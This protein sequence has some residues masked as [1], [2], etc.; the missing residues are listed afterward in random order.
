VT[1]RTAPDHGAGLSHTSAVPHDAGAHGPGRT[2]EARGASDPL[3]V[4]VSGRP[5]S[6]K[7]TVAAQLASA[8]GLS[9]LAKDA[10][11][12]TL[13]DVLGA[14]DVEASR[15]LGRAARLVLTTVAASSTGAVL[16]SVWP[17]GDGAEAALR[18]LPGR[19]VEVHCDIAPELAVQRYQARE[20]QRGASAQVDAE[21]GEDEQS[22]AGR[23]VAGG[24]PVLR[25][26]TSVEVDAA[27]L[28][29]RIWDV[30]AR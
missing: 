19:V 18:T 13:V 8:L 28:V 14:P 16:D 22:R 21:R 17:P 20:S 10:I 7:S 25:V 26:D 11:K 12:Q 29:A 24:W 9:L 4:V 23:A 1:T 3:F 2:A 5:G 6:G 30:A 27:A 15:E